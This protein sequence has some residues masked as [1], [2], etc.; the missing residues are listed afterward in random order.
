M[1]ELKKILLF[2]GISLLAELLR[3][4]L[5]ALLETMT[6]IG[7]A[8]LAISAALAI[9]ASYFANRKFVFATG[10][11]IGKSLLGIFAFYI[12][13]MPIS[14]WALD[15]LSLGETAGNVFSFIARLILEYPYCRFILYGEDR[16]PETIAQR[17]VD[18]NGGL[19]TREKLV[20]MDW[21][22]KCVCIL[23]AFLADYT[24]GGFLAYFTGSG[25]TS[26]EWLA[27]SLRHIGLPKMAEDFENYVIRKG[28]SLHDLSQ[29][30]YKKLGDHFDVK[31]LGMVSEM[32]EL[33]DS[34]SVEKAL[35]RFV[36][37]NEEKWQF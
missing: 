27:G 14:S 29:F 13:Y 37:R 10:T 6:V 35:R 8:S 15:Q 21:D 25:T 31:L 9:L 7:L 23:S 22:E 36:I 20:Q 30:D 4:G 12:V 5:F 26:A 1:K 24:V 16:Q 3:Y 32:E 34:R 19:V 28:L 33:I 2:G 17:I 11:K 18:Q